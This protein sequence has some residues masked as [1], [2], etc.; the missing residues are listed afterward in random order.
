MLAKN[1]APGPDYVDDTFIHNNKSIRDKL[2]N[3]VAEM[4]NG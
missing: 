2:F 4:F 3:Y 1:K